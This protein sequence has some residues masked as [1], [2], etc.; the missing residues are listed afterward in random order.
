MENKIAE[1]VYWVG[2]YFKEKGASVNAFLLKDK[3][4]ALIDTGPSVTQEV[5]L[6]NIK[7][8]ADP[9]SVDY[10][11]LT[12]A[13]VDHCGALG[14]LMEVAKNAKVYTSQIGAMMIP[15]YGFQVQPNVVAP[16]DA[17]D[18][19]KM[20]LRFVSTPIVDTWD[21][22][23]VFEEKNKILFS[24]DAFGTF[25]Q[26]NAE[27]KLFAHGDVSSA[28]KAYHGVKFPWI[29]VASRERLMKAAAELKALKP[30]IIASGHGSLLR[31][32]TAKYFDALA[33]VE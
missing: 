32:D 33:E 2:A 8:I 24:A 5:V 26:P 18:L 12:H 27:W 1:G 22:L 21:T 13:E 3:K 9:A 15:I 23:F 29:K 14:K 20:K 25:G 7:T 19:G 30:E 28:L 17:L 11:V 10:I 4:T 16:E 31:G 6:N